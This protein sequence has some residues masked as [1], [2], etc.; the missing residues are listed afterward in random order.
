[1][2]CPNCNKEYCKY[3]EPREDL[4]QG[5]KRYPKK[6]VNFEAK[7]KKCGWEGQI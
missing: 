2:K 4:F 3:K 1:M 6:R 7:C 5:S